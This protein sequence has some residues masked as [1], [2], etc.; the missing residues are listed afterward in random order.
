MGS[1][2]I[3]AWL[4]GLA[5]GASLV[6]AGTRVVGSGAGSVAARLVTG[7]PERRTGT[8]ETGFSTLIRPGS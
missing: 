5:A 6:I 7:S 8:G 1:A 4:P 2:L 3:T